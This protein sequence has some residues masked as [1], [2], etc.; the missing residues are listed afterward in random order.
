MSELLENTLAELAREIN[1]L[2]AEGHTALAERLARHLPEVQ[3]Y[4]AIWD[5]AY[6]GHQEG[7]WYYDTY[8]PIERS[9]WRAEASRVRLDIALR[10]MRRLNELADQF[11]NKDRHS[12][13]SSISDGHVVFKWCFGTPQAEPQVTPRWE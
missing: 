2:H 6:G 10:R 4:P 11:L 1:A 12:P 9:A 13:S 7:G 5:K 3:I 8:T